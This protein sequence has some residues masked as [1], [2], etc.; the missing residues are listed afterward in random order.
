MDKNVQKQNQS[1]TSKLSQNILVKRNKNI[2]EYHLSLNHLLKI[3]YS[4][5][6]LYVA[7]E[8]PMLRIN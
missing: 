3:I 8:F 5:N 7:N 2:F 1:F 4:F 6:S